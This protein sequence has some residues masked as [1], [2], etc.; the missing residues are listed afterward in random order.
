MAGSRI[1]VRAQMIPA[2]GVAASIVS[3][4]LTT[5]IATAAGTMVVLSVLAMIAFAAM[6]AFSSTW[7]GRSDMASA[8][9]ADTASGDE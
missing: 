5:G 3:F 6:S 4:S 2:S 1:V 9:D 8:A 7:V